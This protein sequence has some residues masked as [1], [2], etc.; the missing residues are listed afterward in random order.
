MVC[1]ARELSLLPAASYDAVYCAH[2]LEHY[3]RHEV[4]KV[5]AG[6]SHVIKPG[7]FAHVIVPDMGEVMRVMA[8]NKVDIDDVLYQ[9]VR[10]PITVLDVVYGYGVEIQG[11]GNDFYAH[12]NCFTQKSPPAMLVRCRVPHLYVSGA[13]IDGT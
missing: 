5:L 2:N 4:P 8:Q 9:S 3:Y 12:K 10:G 1:D 7:G 13:D 11:S 6:F